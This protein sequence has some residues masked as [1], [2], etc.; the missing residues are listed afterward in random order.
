MNSIED[1]RVSVVSVVVVVR[2][3]RLHV[4]LIVRVVAIG[5]LVVINLCTYQL[6]SPSSSSKS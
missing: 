2:T 3:R 4:V 5:G 1:N 6:P